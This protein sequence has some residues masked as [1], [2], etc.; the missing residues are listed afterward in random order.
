MTT[1]VLWFQRSHSLKT[2]RALRLCAGFWRKTMRS[3]AAFS[4]QVAI[5]NSNAV[6]PAKLRRLIKNKKSGRPFGTWIL[7]KRITNRIGLPK[8]LS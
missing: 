1:C 4:D 6:C 8:P 3:C 2:R 5:G 7:T